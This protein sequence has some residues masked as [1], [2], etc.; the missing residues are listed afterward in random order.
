MLLAN[1][2]AADCWNWLSGLRIC[3]DG[4]G[5]LEPGAEIRACLQDAMSG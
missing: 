1:M 3:L 4:G 2:I 5:S